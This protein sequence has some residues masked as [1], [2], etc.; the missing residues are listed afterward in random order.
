[1]CADGLAFRKI[2]LLHLIRQ[3]IKKSAA[4]HSWPCFLQRCE[5]W[6]LL[7]TGMPPKCQE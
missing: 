1:M 5:N 3:F 7:L 4:R 6:S 2:N